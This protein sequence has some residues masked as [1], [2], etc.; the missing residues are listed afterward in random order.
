MSPIQ[1]QCRWIS[2]AIAKSTKFASN[3]YLG[4]F[5]WSFRNVHYLAESGSSSQSIVMYT[6]LYH[7]GTKHA[8]RQ[9]KSLDPI[10]FAQQSN[11]Q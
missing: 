1:Q 11:L 3:D 8:F 6:Y 4:F 9:P 2:I 7:L 5:I 10:E